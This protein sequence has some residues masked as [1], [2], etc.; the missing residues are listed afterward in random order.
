MDFLIPETFIQSSPDKD[1][2]RRRVLLLEI[3]R[4]APILMNRSSD[5]PVHIWPYE[6]VVRLAGSHL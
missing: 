6:P 1:I 4:K 5:L 2:I 3:I